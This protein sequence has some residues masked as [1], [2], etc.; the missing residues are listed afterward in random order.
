MDHE[1]VDHAP[2]V[3]DSANVSDEAIIGARSR[4]WDLVQVREGARIGDDCIVG[5]GAYIDA[6]VP[7][8]DR[9]KI[10]NYALIYEPASLATGV[11]IGPAAVLTNDTYPRAIGPDG[12]L[13][14]AADWTPVGV[15]V[16]EGASV[17]ARAVCVA[18]VRIGRWAMVA[19]GAVVTADVTDF[20]L[21]VGTPARRIGWV[22]RTG[23]R[24]RADADGWICPDTGQ[25]FREHEGTLYEET[26][27]EETS[28][29]GTGRDNPPAG[30]GRRAAPG[31]QP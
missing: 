15:T 27:Y 3:A 29:E 14:S 9:C 2:M 12:R 20:A 22:G 11:F 10:Q 28:H 13:K 16:A 8:G 5:R 25:R 23:H 31:T 30:H 21:V 26:A 24:L 6:G 1:D 19:A 17:G 7:I 18:P 4:I